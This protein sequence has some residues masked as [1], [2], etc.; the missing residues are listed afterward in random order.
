MAGFG[1][2]AGGFAGGF[3]QT[4]QL[5]QEKERLDKIAKL[6]GQLLEL[7]IKGEQQKQDATEKLSDLSS[8]FGPFEIGETTTV[9]G[10]KQTPITSP[11]PK[12]LTEILADPDGRL[13]AIQAGVLP[14]IMQAEQLEARSSLV[15]AI[16]ES[17]LSPSAFLE[18]PEGAALAVRAGMSPGEFLEANRAGNFKP[19]ANIQDFMFSQQNPEFLSFLRDRSEVQSGGTGMGRGFSDAFK[20][21]QDAGLQASR[22]INQYSRVLQLNELVETGRLAGARTLAAELAQELGV[23]VEGLDATQAMRAITNRIAL[24]LRNPAGGAGMPG[25][26]SDTDR[27]FLVNSVPSLTL[28]PEGNKLIAQYAIKLA[29]RDK[30][31]FARARKYVQENGLL[32]SRFFDELEMWS[33][34]N[35]LFPKEDKDRLAG[36]TEDG[37]EIVN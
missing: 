8:G 4:M 13:A 30:D 34:A 26:M 10:R 37:W 36:K 35:P 14:Q 29:E 15:N 6:Q 16:K 7:R 28:T 11:E 31:V 5:K 12:S 33:D 22:T 27:T 25:A 20:N 19:T 32:D 24:E 3:M 23:D 2:F 1:D 21:I 18:S 17:G 9:N